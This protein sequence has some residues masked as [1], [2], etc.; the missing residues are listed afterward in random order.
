MISKI[1]K[2]ADSPKAQESMLPCQQNIFLAS[3]EVTFLEEV[4]FNLI[5]FH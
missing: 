5:Y 4:T 3:N 2:F 1:F